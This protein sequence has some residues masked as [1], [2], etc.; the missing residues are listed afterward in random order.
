MLADSGPE[1]P[2]KPQFE[3]IRRIKSETDNSGLKLTLYQYQTCP[4]CCKVRAFLD[5]HGF[6]YDVVEVNSVWRTQLKWT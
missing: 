6:S 3:P 4:F 2:Q 5:Y 1:K